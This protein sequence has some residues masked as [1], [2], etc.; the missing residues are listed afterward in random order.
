MIDHDLAAGEGFDVTLPPNA[1][2]RLALPPDAEGETW[3]QIGSATWVRAVAGK[4]TLIE[5]IDKTQVTQV[6]FR[7]DRPG[8][9]VDD[10]PGW[11][12]ETDALKGLAAEVVDGLARQLKASVPTLPLRAPP[13]PLSELQLDWPVGS[14]HHAAARRWRRM[15]GSAA[16]TRYTQGAAEDAGQAAG[17]GANLSARLLHHLSAIP[18]PA[19]ARV[20]LVSEPDTGLVLSWEQIGN[21]DLLWGA[22]AISWSK[23]TRVVLCAPLS[24]EKAVE[25]RRL[26]ALAHLLAMATAVEAAT[27][28]CA[29]P[30]QLCFCTMGASKMAATLTISPSDWGFELPRMV[31]MVGHGQVPDAFRLRVTD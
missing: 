24:P 5:G 19:E 9:V 14:V 3:W 6:R 26:G 17:S 22:E 30:L 10:D 31:R 7:T 25:E 20:H 8:L 27:G 4:A 16:L 12:N 28:G 2:A 29:V 11:V 18:R 15:A 23:L 1:S 21:P 13:L